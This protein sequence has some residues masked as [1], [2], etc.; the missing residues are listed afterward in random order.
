MT[1]PS[2]PSDSGSY[3]EEDRA[4]ALRLEPTDLQ[5]RGRAP[6]MEYDDDS[7]DGYSTHK[8]M[9]D[10]SLWQS[11]FGPPVRIDNQGSTGALVDHAGLRML[12]PS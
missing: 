7:S 2:A 12:A 8:R 10:S 6:D 1:R 11:L 9:D 5:A 4:T 3:G